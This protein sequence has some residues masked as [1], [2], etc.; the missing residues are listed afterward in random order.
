METRQTTLDLSGMPPR[1]RDELLDF[2]EFL[3]Q[4]YGKEKD[5]SMESEGK[6]FSNFLAN[7]VN[8]DQVT[9]LSREALHERK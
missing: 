3:C 9:Q 1:V 6:T 5:T 8:V 2:Y 7:P 4:K